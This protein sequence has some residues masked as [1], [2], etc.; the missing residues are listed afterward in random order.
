M[1][2]HPVV[3]ALMAEIQNLPSSKEMPGTS[4]FDRP[5][6]TRH[7]QRSRH[8]ECWPL[9]RRFIGGKNARGAAGNDHVDPGFVK[10]L[11]QFEDDIDVLVLCAATQQKD[12]GTFQRAQERKPRAPCIPSQHLFMPVGRDKDFFLMRDARFHQHFRGKT[13]Y[14]R[15]PA[16][17]LSYQWK[18]RTTGEAEGLRVTL[19]QNERVRECKRCDARGRDRS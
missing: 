19:R 3:I 8:D 15:N 13:G 12:V 14:G 1:T 4:R 16:R 2:G 18:Q 6:P 7:R 17:P 5:P 9:R 10:P 11:R